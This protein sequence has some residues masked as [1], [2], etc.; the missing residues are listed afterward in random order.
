MARWDGMDDVT[1]G[2]PIASEP[3]PEL[4]T[5][6]APA[7]VNNAICHYYFRTAFGALL[8]AAVGV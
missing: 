8:R 5:I 6:G 4:A 1:G 2:D 7:K 3:G